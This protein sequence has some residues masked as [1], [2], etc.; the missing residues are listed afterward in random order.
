MHDAGAGRQPL[1]VT[2]A[3]A[4]RRAQRIAVIDEAFAH[5]RHRLE[6]AVRM[7]RKPRHRIAVVH[8]PAVLAGE[9]LADVAA[10]ERGGGAQAVVTLRIEID[11][12][13]AD[14]ERVL[15]LP[16]EGKRRDAEDGICAHA[17]S[18]ETRPQAV[19]PAGAGGAPAEGFMLTSPA[20][21]LLFARVIQCCSASPLSP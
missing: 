12:V 8:T 21:P 18:L 6:A 19:K 10:R 3:E 1:H 7:L 9:V 16:G 4:R 11:V 5:E 14:E 2:A 20:S 13:D 17:A 15:G